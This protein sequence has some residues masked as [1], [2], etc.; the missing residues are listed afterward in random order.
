ML[1]HTLAI[2]HRLDPVGKDDLEDDNSAS[3]APSLKK[4][5]ASK[6]KDREEAHG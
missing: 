3:D 1:N 6:V 5:K 2:K 4:Q